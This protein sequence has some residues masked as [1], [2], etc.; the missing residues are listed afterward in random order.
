MWERDSTSS[1][2]LESD[3]MDLERDDHGGESTLKYNCN[4]LEAYH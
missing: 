2:D 1:E 4:R 3:E